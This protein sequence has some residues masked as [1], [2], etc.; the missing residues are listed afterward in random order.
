[1]A[2]YRVT[3]PSGEIYEV[4]APDDASESDVLAYAQKQ[5]AP[6]KAEAIDP[7]EGMSTAEKALAGFGKAFVDTGRG[8]GQLLRKILPA[9]ASDAMGLPTQQDIDEAKRLDAPL[10]KTKAGMFGNIGGSALMAIPAAPLPG[11]NS[12]TGGALIGSI[13]AALQPTATGESRGENMAWGAGG[14]AAGALFAKILGRAVRPVQTTLPD[15]LAPLAVRAERDFGIPL[16]A[17]QRTGSKPLKIIDAV[18]ENLPMSASRQGVEKA[19]QRSAYN[20]AVLREIG[21]NADSATPDILNAARARIGKQFEEIS[22]RNSV[23]IGDEFL[24]ALT[25]VD[26]SRTPFSSPQISAVVDHALELASKGKI[27]GAEYQRVRTSLTNAAKGAWGSDPEKGQALKAV[28][29]ALDRAADASISPADQAAWKTARGQWA[30]LKAV[31]DAAKPISADA[32]SGNIS[33]AKLAGAIMKNNR[34]GMIYGQGDQVMPDLARIGQAFIKEQVPDSGTAQR[35]IYQALLTGSPAAAGMIM[36]NPVMLGTALSTLALP[37]V[38]QR[39]LHSNAGRAYFSRG[40]VPN[41]PTTAQ[42]A[43]FLNQGSAGAG[44]ALLT[45]RPE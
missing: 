15:N 28:R 42:I 38:A 9:G 4:T 34:H 35:A 5:F 17:A 18:L 22:A 26:A 13:L 36:S 12:I 20:R 19:A 27:S 8:A 41:N 29:N 44:S 7:T 21:E 25:R 6:K 3:S 14:G 33:P 32:V 11:A 10:L 23:D 30:N 31:E 43:R 45:N 40:L 37:N 24:D 1:M 39:V 16:N 2:K